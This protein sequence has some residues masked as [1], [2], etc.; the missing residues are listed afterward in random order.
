M[1]KGENLLIRGGITK[2]GLVTAAIAKA[3]GCVVVS[4]S[5]KKVGEDMLESAGAKRVFVDG[6]K[7]AEE[8]RKIFPEGVEGSGDHWW[9]VRFAFQNIGVDIYHRHDNVSRFP[10]VRERKSG[11][12]YWLDG[13]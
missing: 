1:E 8:V 3:F 6:E 11:L 10:P 2:I 13:E 9:V 12:Y 5:R 4:T 7:I